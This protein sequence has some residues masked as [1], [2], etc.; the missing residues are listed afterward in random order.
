M[1]RERPAIHPGPTQDSPTSAVPIALFATTAT[2]IRGSSATTATTPRMD[3]FNISQVVSDAAGGTLNVCGE[4]IVN[5]DLLHAASVVEGIWVPVKSSI[6]NSGVCSGNSGCPQRV[7]INDTLGLHFD[8]PGPA[9][10]SD[11]CHDANDS[12]CTVI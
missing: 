7:L 9:E 3:S 10:S 5:T 2:R 6:N 12:G 8:P 4:N 1:L 11:E